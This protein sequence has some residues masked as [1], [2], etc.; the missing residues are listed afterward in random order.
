MA[1]QI[2]FAGSG[3][4]TQLPQFLYEAGYCWSGAVAITQPRRV[5]ATTVAARVAFEMGVRLGGLVGYSVKLLRRPLFCSPH[6]NAACLFFLRS[7]PEC[8]LTS[9]LGAAC[10][11]AD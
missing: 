1:N 10:A 6:L 2:S 7:Y 8:L 9:C 4:T 3:K 11:D 5:A